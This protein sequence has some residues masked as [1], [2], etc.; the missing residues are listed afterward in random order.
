MALSDDEKRVIGEEVRQELGRILK[1]WA[2]LLGITNVIVIGSLIGYIF[3]VIPERATEKVDEKVEN[4]VREKVNDSVNQ[5]IEERLQSAD[6]IIN[7][8]EEKIAVLI[9][10]SVDR[11]NDQVGKV[12]DRVI[13]ESMGT[14][15]KAV[16]TRKDLEATKSNAEDL[17]T[18]ITVLQSSLENIKSSIQNLDE[19]QLLS[20]TQLE[21]TIGDVGGGDQFIKQQQEI[22]EKQ[23]RNEKELTDLVV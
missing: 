10:N 19:G 12:V 14:H 21:K 13:D 6:D 5:Q 18:E 4:L 15:K 7:V 23:T 2:T 16:E 8:A 11:W 20:V 3:F 9:D 17:N 22:L 1:T